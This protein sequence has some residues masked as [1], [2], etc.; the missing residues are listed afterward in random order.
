MKTEWQ[1]EWLCYQISLFTLTCQ[2]SLSVCYLTLLWQRSLSYRNQ[3]I[4]L[5]SKYLRLHIESICRRLRIITQLTFWDIST[6]DIWNV[7]LQTYRNNRIC[8]IVAY[9]L[10]KIQISRVNNSKILRFEKFSGYCFYMQPS[11]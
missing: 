3:S 10:R 8:K 7:Y 2:V 9:L 6:W 11:I 4:D 5:Q 1:I